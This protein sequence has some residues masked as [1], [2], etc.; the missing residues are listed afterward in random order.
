M[1]EESWSRCW[2]AIGAKG[3]GEELMH[4]LI[5]AYSEPQRKYHTTQHLLECLTIFGENM[6][7]A[8]EP[9]EVEIA[10]WFHDAIYD[11]RASD[12]EERSAE[13]AVSALNSAAVEQDRISRI[14]ALVLATKHTALPEAEDQ[15]LL[16]DIDLSILGANTE[17]FSEYEQQ[18]RQE[19]AYVPGFLYRRKRKQILKEFLSRNPIY[20]TSAL[21]KRF[22]EQARRNIALSTEA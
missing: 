17:R 7:C 21:R 14:K 13:W 12:N 16:I 2:N 4:R 19:Y 5:D 15:Q 11:V 10:L 18:V 8:K 9:G 22:E 3:K 1:F 6:D 20:S